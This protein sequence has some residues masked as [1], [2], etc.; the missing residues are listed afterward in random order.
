MPTKPDLNK[1]V[2]LLQCHATPGDEDEV[3][4]WLTADWE[5]AGWIVTR[6]GQ[7][8]VSATR[9]EAR[10]DAPTVLVGAH[11]DSPGY[12]VETIDSETLTCVR[13]GSPRFAGSST[14]AVLKTN[15]RKHQVTLEKSGDNDRE[16]TFTINCRAKVKHGDR[17]CFQSRPQTVNDAFVLAP[18][19]DNRV[20]CFVLSELANSR[21]LQRE[22][23][24]NLI[25]GATST[26]E[27][28]GFGAPVLANATRPDL[29]IC[30]DATYADEAQNVLLGKGPV[31]TLSDASVI[32]SCAQRDL[33]C[34]LFKRAGIPLQTEVYNYSG[35][36]AR[37]FPAQG[38]PCP[39]LALLVATEG[40]HS[41]VERVAVSDIAAV[42][43]ILRHWATTPR[44]IKQL[45]G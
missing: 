34:K 4:D 7:Y 16:A 37:A 6:H 42:T 8:A 13:I 21:E 45:L 12:T 43:E 24:V 28:C 3:R 5:A 39:V 25:L 1:F 36:D 38:L 14:N 44:D 2:E 9:P 30:L 20:G 35:T 15:R 22:L 27:M 19:V 33:I 18:F 11:M 29:A 10:P 26:E 32:L 41:P 40:N 17:V 23:P 31:L